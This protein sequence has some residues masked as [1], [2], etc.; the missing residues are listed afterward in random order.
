MGG[1]ELQAERDPQRQLGMLA[2][3]S[4]ELAQDLDIGR[5][6]VGIVERSMALTASSYGAAVTL[7]I[8]GQIENFLHRGLSP[9]EVALL[10]HLPEGKGLLGAVLAE[11]KVIR[12]ED[13]TTHPASVGF[14]TAHVPMRA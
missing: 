1:G 3:I 8:D 13:I 2:D 12:I 10:P 5:I 14:P 7:T 4:L 11:R 9:E 6:L